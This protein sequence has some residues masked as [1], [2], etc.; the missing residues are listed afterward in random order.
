L[1]TQRRRDDSFEDLG[2]S[3]PVI[4][5]IMAMGFE[6]PTPVQ[7]G[8][9]PAICAGRDVVAEAPS[10]SGK[11]LAFAGPALSIVDPSLNATQVLIVC[12]TGNLAEQTTQVLEK[13]ATFAHP[14]PRITCVTG[15]VRLARGARYQPQV[16]VCTP[17]R[18][19]DACGFLGQQVGEDHQQQ[20][21]PLLS[22]EG[23]RL[24]VMDEADEFLDRPEFTDQLAALVRRLPPACAMGYFSATMTRSTL[25]VI[26][27][28]RL[29]SAECTRIKPDPDEGSSGMGRV[30]PAIKHL[31]VHVGQGLGDRAWEA[32][33]ET[34]AE[35]CT[36]FG[37][38]SVVVF[39]KSKAQRDF[40]AD[41]FGADC[42]S[43]RYTVNL[44]TFRRRRGLVLLATDA[45]SRGID[46]GGVAAVVNF[47]MPASSTAYTQRVGR[48][49]RFGKAGTAV[50]LV[51]EED[52]RY[53][54]AMERDLG[55]LLEA[56]PADVRHLPGAGTY[57]A[58][59]PG[60]DER[61][62]AVAAAA[63]TPPLA[64]R[65]VPAPALAR[66]VTPP[67]AHQGRQKASPEETMPPSVAAALE[68]A[69]VALQGE[70]AALRAEASA[71]A[72]ALK[73]ALTESQEAVKVAR[74][75]AAAAREELRRGLAA[76]RAEMKE[77]IAAAAV[78]TAAGTAAGAAAVSAEGEQRG[79]EEGEEEEEEEGFTITF[80]EE[81]CEEGCSGEE[82]PPAAALLSMSSS[83]PVST[84]GKQPEDN[85]GAGG[86]GGEAAW[87][88]VGGVKKRQPVGAASGP[89][90]PWLGEGQLAWRRLKLGATFRGRVVTTLAQGAFLRF[91]TD[92][93]AF[94]K[95]GFVR[96]AGGG[97]QLEVG[98]WHHV[99]VQRVEGGRVDLALV[100]P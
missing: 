65:A 45:C 22:V 39:A 10:G 25:E 86:F 1:I 8:S 50:T 95:D 35:V 60:T 94:T 6:R 54:S 56:L 74:A 29:V 32:R 38:G 61:A 5:G 30:R 52:E 83:E 12:P 44:A 34:T 87:T 9:I 18:L 82:D 72:T 53:F 78:G 67:P 19:L 11:T 81:G 40:L 68:A 73:A 75:E 76:V 92:G 7:F 27:A 42:G 79:K 46:V 14:K 84:S 20:R 97:K 93:G 90:K 2:L 33:A 96:G 51:V 4:R 57:D 3:A 71:E 36:A 26:D 48:C 24:C 88:S 80:E 70:V 89:P 99:R 85:D 21:P 59:R 64:A 23:V 13:L 63:S 47:E 91:G 15:G 31:Y 69:L 100:G 41:G 49:G 66:A 17:N 37:G 28:E 98:S 43:S 58:E 62:A 55:Y 77:K 16:V